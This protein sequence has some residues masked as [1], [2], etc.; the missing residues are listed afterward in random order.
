MLVPI[1]SLLVN[2]EIAEVFGVIQKNMD[3]QT[4]HE[5]ILKIFFLTKL[6]FKA[7]V[8]FIF[9]FS[10][11]KPMLYTH[12]FHQKNYLSIIPPPLFIVVKK[13]DKQN[14]LETESLEMLGVCQEPATSTWNL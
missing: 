8:S 7:Y 11:Y 14:P 9:T 10:N 4:L 1:V 6:K 2:T 3:T 12:F 13:K 5:I